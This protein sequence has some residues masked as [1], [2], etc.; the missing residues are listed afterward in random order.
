MGSE[1][2]RSLSLITEPVNYSSSRIQSHINLM[3][4]LLPYTEAWSSSDRNT[5]SLEGGSPSAL[6]GQQPPQEDSEAA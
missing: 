6:K 4:F 1:R 5:A 2:L 3:C